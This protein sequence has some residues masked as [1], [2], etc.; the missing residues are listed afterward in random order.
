MARFAGFAATLFRGVFSY[1]PV[2]LAA[3]LVPQPPQPPGVLNA[4]VSVGRMAGGYGCLPITHS[5]LIR[6]TL[7][8]EGR[9]YKA[10][11]I[12]RGQA[13]RFWVRQRP[14]V[15]GLRWLGADLVVGPLKQ[16]IAASAQRS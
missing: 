12:G 3:K 9:I 4:E 16:N 6:R 8:G 2:W 5:P 13:L 14:L 15:V 10:A 1:T 11:D 7:N